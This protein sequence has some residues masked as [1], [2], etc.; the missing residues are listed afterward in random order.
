MHLYVNDRTVRMH[1]VVLCIVSSIK[2]VLLV[3]NTKRMNTLA[4]LLEKVNNYFGGNS[5]NS[6]V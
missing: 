2:P 3:R 1:R 6:S 5:Q 4:R